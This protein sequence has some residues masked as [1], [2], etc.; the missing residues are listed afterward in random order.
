M[1]YNIRQY[2]ESCWCQLPLNWLGQCRPQG[3]LLDNFQNGGSANDLIT[4]TSAKAVTMA[5]VTFNPWSAEKYACKQ[6]NNAKVK[7]FSFIHV[8][9]WCTCSWK[10][11][12]DFIAT[13][14]YLILSSLEVNCCILLK[15]LE[16]TCNCCV[17]VGRWPTI[18][19]RFL[20]R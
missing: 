10:L 8:Q 16:V 13:K 7:A 12:P 9:L 3:L 20:L 19:S 5:A 15:C 6:R 11:E 18:S 1:T 14:T 17:R 4:R 2:S